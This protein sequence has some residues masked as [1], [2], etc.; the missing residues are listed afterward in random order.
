VLEQLKEAGLVL[1]LDKCVFGRMA[2]DFLGH[3]ITAEGAA[4]LGDYVAAVRDFLL[5]ADKQACSS[6][7]GW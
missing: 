6:S 2:V 1:N 4:P 3:R 5:P 7:S